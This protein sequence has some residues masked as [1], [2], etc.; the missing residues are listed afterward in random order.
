M[1]EQYMAYFPAITMAPNASLKAEGNL[2]EV[3]AQPHRSGEDPTDQIPD[4]GEQNDKVPTLAPQSEDPRVRQEEENRRIIHKG[5]DLVAAQL[6]RTGLFQSG[7]ESANKVRKL[8]LKIPRLAL[9]QR[10]WKPHAYI[11]NLRLHLTGAQAP[12]GN[13]AQLAMALV[14]LLAA[15]RKSHPL[16][17]ATGQLGEQPSGTSDK[18]PDVE[19]LSVGKLPE[20]LRLVERLAI[21]KKLPRG[22]DHADP[23]WLFTPTT[24]D[25]DGEPV[26][27]GTLSEVARL[28]T[29]GVTV[30]PVK[31]LGEAARRLKT[32]RARW[33]WQDSA[34]IGGIFCVP[35]ILGAVIY[36]WPKSIIIQPQPQ[37][38]TLE[39]SDPTSEKLSILKSAYVSSNQK[40]HLN[41]GSQ[42]E[43]F[44]Y[45]LQL[46]SDGK[47]HIKS[48]EDDNEEMKVEDIIKLSPK[49]FTLFMLVKN[50]S[51]SK[52]QQEKL[53]KAIL[54]LHL[55]PKLCINER[56]QFTFEKCASNTQCPLLSFRGETPVPTHKPS[57]E[58]TCAN[59]AIKL[60]E[61]LKHETPGIIHLSGYAFQVIE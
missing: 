21:D 34:W 49:N 24:F 1:K 42:N 39:V 17:I 59:W 33:M 26:A 57:P 38:L 9:Y 30:I 29:L 52:D 36:G 60:L 11:D 53:R 55:Q 46:H 61:T 8:G 56:Y 14:L 5:W 27:V 6:Y 22:R 58:P 45:L 50:Q 19:V 7:S 35:L 28:Q 16:V 51:W 48:I 18:D 3:Y 54:G 43:K 15:T 10:F 4:Q 13:S 12:E 44:R 32:Q 20:K 2:Y 23:V 47:L 40:L 41:Y 37:D 25:N 31:T